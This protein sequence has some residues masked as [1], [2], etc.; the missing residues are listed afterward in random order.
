MDVFQSESGVEP[1]PGLQKDDCE[2]EV[3][4]AD[5]DGCLQSNR[6]FV[7]T[8]IPSMPLFGIFIEDQLF[9]NCCLFSNGLSFE[10]IHQ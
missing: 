2:L 3:V 9:N 4:L 7:S 1:L 5:L 10:E 8:S 6:F